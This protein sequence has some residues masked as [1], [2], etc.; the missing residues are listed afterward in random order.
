MGKVHFNNGIRKCCRDE[1]V[2]DHE[3][4]ANMFGLS[5]VIHP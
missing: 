4:R 5:P 1:P 3:P 2:Y